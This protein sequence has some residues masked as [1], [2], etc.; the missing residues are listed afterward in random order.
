MSGRR[1]AFINPFGTDAYDRIIADTLSPL[2][3]SDTALEIR[4]LIG[5]PV[6]IDYFWPKHL[7]EVAVFEECLR[8][9][10]EG[11]DAI[12]VGCC[13]D[14][15]VRVAREL[16]DVP[17]VGPLEAALNMA[18]YFGHR[19]T[20]ITDHH[21]A[22]PYIEDLVRL[23]GQQNV[24]NVRCI[25]WWVTEMIREPSEVAKDA[26]AECERALEE[27]AADLAILGCTIIAACLT[28]HTRTTG[29]FGDVP[30]V[31]PNVLALKSA[32]ALADLRQRGEYRLSR[33]NYYEKQT[34]RDPAEFEE[35]RTR[36]R[37][38]RTEEDPSV[39]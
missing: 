27:D 26:V 35:I 21:K 14:P 8:L 15:G 9:E 38:T 17:V 16:V 24:R 34:A 18:S 20:I 11:V 13:Y 12:I 23:Y 25:D 37:L 31:N 2:T 29:E 19:P 6:N 39:R 28:Q 3:M 4:N 22:V 30:V 10:K 33:R 36:Y 7:V 5:A 1:I 32:E